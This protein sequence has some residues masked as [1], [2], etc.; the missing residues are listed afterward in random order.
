MIAID[1]IRLDQGM[2]WYE[3]RSGA[4]GSFTYVAVTYG[5]CVYWLDGE[6]LVLEKGDFLLIPAGI[7]YYGKSVPT[8]FHEKIV[9]GFAC[10]AS[11][12]PPLP[13][14]SGKAWV[15]TRAGS[16]EWTIERLRVIVKEWAERTDYADI[17][18]S[19]VLL[20]I[21]T[22]WCRELARGR[23]RSETQ[24]HAERMKQYVQDH[25]RERIT[26]EHLGAA[27]GRSANHAAALFH[28][29]TG[30][31]ISAYVHAV[32]MRTAVYMLEESL[33][34]VNEIAEYLGYSDVSYFHRIYKRTYGHSPA[35][36]VRH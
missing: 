30:Q 15:R 9:I 5:R 32:R 3:E 28:R 16:L 18:A 4:A 22:L 13:I 7:P 23:M 12:S 36:S 6:K 27:I 20:E 19:A 24:G 2:N 34:T 17:R 29:A 33:L 14:L 21:L 10:G 26:K 35:K 1:F 31:T 8:M 11:D 25:Y